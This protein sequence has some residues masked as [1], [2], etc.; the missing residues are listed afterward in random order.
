MT[1]FISWNLFQMSEFHSL[2]VKYLAGFMFI[3]VT[4]LMV[5]GTEPDMREALSVVMNGSVL[6]SKRTEGGQEEAV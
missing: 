4:P 3:V 6:C 2:V 1:I 5:L